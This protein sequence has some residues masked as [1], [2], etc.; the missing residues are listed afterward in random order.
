MRERVAGVMLDSLPCLVLIR[1]LQLQPGGTDGCNESHGRHHREAAATALGR[2]ELPCL[3]ILELM[4]PPGDQNIT[5]RV[6]F[7][8]AP[9]SSSWLGALAPWSLLLMRN[10]EGNDGTTCGR[11]VCVSHPRMYACWVHGILPGWLQGKQRATSV[12]LLLNGGDRT[13][14]PCETTSEAMCQPTA[15]YFVFEASILPTLITPHIGPDC[16]Y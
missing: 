10:T 2:D 15:L 6:R 4:R 8:K 12:L 7:V 13:E 16:K 9:Y 1:Q 14:S 11:L 3:H 5:N